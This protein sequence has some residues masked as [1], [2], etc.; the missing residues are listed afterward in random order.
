MG[1]CYTLG[2]VP[3]L[4]FL[5]ES[6]FCADSYK[7]SFRWDSKLK[8]PYVYIYK[9]SHTRMK[10]P[11]VRVRVWW[12]GGTL[13]PSLPQ[14]VKF[15]GW[16]VHAYTPANSIFDGFITNL[17]SILCSLI[18]FLSHALVK[19]KKASTISSLTLLLVIF[20]V[21]M[22][23]RISQHAINEKINIRS[24]GCHCKLVHI[25]TVCTECVQRWQQRHV[26]QAI[27]QPIC[28]K[29][30]TSVDLDLDAHSN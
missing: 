8:S 16:K 4:R 1:D 30:T 7:K 14:P 10:D 27:S 18:E 15:P 25:C 13:T 5:Q 21:T 3:T 23:Q 22:R 11:V 26:A 9:G 2:F 24:F 12:M 6:E 19:G 28:F 29:F 20:W 17:L